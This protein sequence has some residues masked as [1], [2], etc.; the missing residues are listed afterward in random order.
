MKNIFHLLWP[1]SLPRLRFRLCRDVLLLLALLLLPQT[2]VGAASAPVVLGP[3]QSYALSGHFEQLI[4][5]T[6]ELTLAEL[7]TAEVAAGFGAIPGNMNRSYTR[8]TVWL[9]FT[10]QRTEAFPAQAWLRLTPPYIDQI[11]VYQQV[12]DD[13]AQ[14]ASYQ[15]AQLGDRLPTKER[16]FLNIDFVT[17]LELPTNRPL[18]VYLQIRSTSTVCLE[19]YIHSHADIVRQGSTTILYQGGYFGIALIISLINLIIFLRIRDRIFLYF[20]LYI[21]AVCLSHLAIQGMLP[22]IVPA[23]AH[24]L[25]YHLIGIST[26]AVAILFSCFLSTLFETRRY[27]WVH[28]YLLLCALIGGLTIVST[29]LGIY[30]RVVSLTSVSFIIT[31]LLMFGLS[32]DAVRRREPAGM[33]YLIAFGVSSFGYIAHLLRLLGLIPLAWWNIHT[34]QY[35]TLLN[36]VLMTLALTERLHAA[37]QQA[38]QAVRESEQKAQELARAM[39]LELR[40]ALA[41]EKQALERQNRFLAMLSH[42]YRTPLAIIQANLNLLELDD[43]ADKQNARQLNTMKHALSR[44]V[45]LLEVSLQQEKLGHFRQEPHYEM[46]ELTALIDTVLDKAEGFWPERAFVFTPGEVGGP[47]ICGNP[48]QLETA[49]LNLLDN[50]CKYSP[51][52]FD[53]TLACQTDAD[54]VVVEIVN[55]GSGPLPTEVERLF[56]KHQRGANSLETEGSGLGLWIVRQI[57]DN[58]GG[59]IR[60][61]PTRE[62]GICARMCLPTGAVS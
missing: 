48:A 36:M 11:T 35:A 58:H 47:R 52:G 28:R 40:T 50:A 9:R 61:V 23:Y 56:E 59:S 55:Q 38:L 60:L 57:V 32:I 31:L 62:A 4:D 24:L 49:L 51:E 26:G 27:P 44:L 21:F 29:P 25:S 34:I 1:V 41:N 39:T 3:Q 2:P 53:I 13:P 6:G 20:G 16:S 45:E 22:L 54:Q 7:L 12:G 19:G 10:V 5:P 8:D 15:V 46:I 43:Q 30:G 42:E 17:P 33:I 37:E 14:P 18:T